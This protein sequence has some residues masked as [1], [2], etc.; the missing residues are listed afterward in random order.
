MS[1][2]ASMRRPNWDMLLWWVLANTLGAVAGSALAQALTSEIFDV[3]YPWYDTGFMLRRA[4]AT[5]LV[6][7]ATLGLVEWLVLRRYLSGAFLWLVATPIGWALGIGT[8]TYLSEELTAVAGL[9]SGDVLRDVLA[10]LSCGA[11]VGFTQCI[12]FRRRLPRVE[13]WVLA[14]CMAWVIVAVTIRP[15]MD[16]IEGLQLPT[17]QVLPEVLSWMNIL[18]TMWLFGVLELTT[19]L[20]LFWLL[21]QRCVLP[22]GG[23]VGEQAGEREV[24][25]QKVRREA[26]YDS[27]AERRSEL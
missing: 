13:F 20:T 16:G 2:R 27:Q 3:S 7:G 17:I 14:N 21:R 15:V 19:G 1:E 4:G 24:D 26:H 12:G 10:T 23:D 11:I 8:A 9:Q 18:T 6:I 22:A 25:E 5:G